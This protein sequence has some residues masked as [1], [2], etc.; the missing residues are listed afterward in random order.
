MAGTAFSIFGTMPEYNA[1][2]PPRLYVAEMHWQR[3]VNSTGLPGMPLA[4]GTDA[5]LST[6]NC[7]TWFCEAGFLGRSCLQREDV[8]LSN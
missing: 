4:C 6:Q 7:D 2:M 5:L 3:L 1:C 8:V